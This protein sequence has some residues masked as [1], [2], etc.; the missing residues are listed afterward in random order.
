MT[1]EGIRKRGAGRPVAV[2]GDVILPLPAQTSGD[3]QIVIGFPVVL[4]KESCVKCVGR[5]AW[6]AGGVC[7]QDGQRFALIVRLRCKCKRAVEVRVRG[8]GVAVV[9]D[10]CAE[11]DG[12]SAQ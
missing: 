4:Q 8:V 6:C 7:Q 9:A 3:S 11:L 1:V 10:A 2:V 12:V 5:H